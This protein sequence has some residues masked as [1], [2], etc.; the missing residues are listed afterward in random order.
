MEKFRLEYEKLHRAL[1][2]SH[3]NEKRL[4]AKC[5][6][7]SADISGNVSKVQSALKMTQDDNH[8]ITFLKG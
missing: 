4:L 1:K 8:N 3:E 6:E 2:V 7:L 5:R